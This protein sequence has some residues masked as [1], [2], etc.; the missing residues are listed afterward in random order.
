MTLHVVVGGQFGSEGKGKV[1]GWL[2]NQAVAPLVIRVGGPNAGHTVVDPILG[3]VALRQ[4]P[5]GFVNAAASLAIGAGS[6]VEI[7]ILEEEIKRLGPGLGKVLVDQSA[8]ILTQEDHDVEANQGMQARLGSTQKGIGAARQRRLARTAETF[9]DLVERGYD[10]HSLACVDVASIAATFLDHGSDVII[11]GTQGYGLGLH[12][13]FYPFCTS[14][15]TTAV[16][17]LAQ[18]RISPWQVNQE[19]LSVWVVCRVYPIRVA[20][21]SGPLLNET[22][23]DAL[24]LPE[25]RTTVTQ[26]IRRVGEW[27]PD[28]VAAAVAANGGGQGDTVKI[29][30]SMVDQKFPIVTDWDGPMRRSHLPLDLLKFISEI[31][32]STGVRVAALGTGP[33]TTIEVTS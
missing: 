12:S 15:D 4:V 33:A 24:G 20:G 2:A 21:N 23:W 32:M 11:E 18:A 10:H 30:L 29:Y 3:P 9:R 27:D 17:F 26:K 16:D 5:V 6:E 31:E 8:T 13:E 28:L 19:D 1:V 25:E 22:T 14:N 7:S